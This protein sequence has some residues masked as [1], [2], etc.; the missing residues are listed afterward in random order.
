MIITIHQNRLINFLKRKVIRTKTFH[1]TKYKTIH[2][3][4]PKIKIS[5]IEKVIEI[6]NDIHQGKMTAASVSIKVTNSIF[7][8]PAN[9][10]CKAKVRAL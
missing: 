4:V 2:C 8:N 3:P 1:T 7:G 5:N 6:I 10:T 9:A